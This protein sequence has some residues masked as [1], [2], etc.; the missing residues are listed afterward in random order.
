[1]IQKIG[2]LCEIEE[3]SELSYCE[4]INK[5]S[6]K[7]TQMNYNISYGSGMTTAPK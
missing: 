3:L 7:S 6:K 5:V 2:M 4:T 1:M